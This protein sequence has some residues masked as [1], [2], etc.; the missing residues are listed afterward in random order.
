V[1]SPFSP[2]GEADEAG[3]VAKTP[4]RATDGGRSMGGGNGRRLVRGRDGQKFAYA[5]S[6]FFLYLF[7]YE[8]SKIYGPSQILQKYTSAAVVHGVKDITPW[9]AAA[10]VASSGSLALTPRATALRP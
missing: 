1:P 7:Y 2:G 3:E 5:T 4:A 9:P 8:F 6:E 10:G